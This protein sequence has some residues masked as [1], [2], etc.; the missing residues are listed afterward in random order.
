MFSYQQGFSSAVKFDGG[1]NNWGGVGS[2]GIAWGNNNTVGSTV[3]TRTSYMDGFQHQTKQQQQQASSNSNNVSLYTQ[4]YHEWKA[5]ADSATVTA[6][7]K[8]WATYYADLA[9]R[10]AHFFHENPYSTQPPPMDLPPTPP[11]SKT[12]PAA[13][14]DQ[15]QQ[16]V[17]DN[18]AERSNT[19]TS[20][21]DPRS[22]QV[23]V[24]RCLQQCRTQKEKDEIISSTKTVLQK[25]IREGS[26]HTKDWSREPL[27]IPPSLNTGK[28][29][30]SS[31]LAWS[32]SVPPTMVSKVLQS[33]FPSSSNKASK[34]AQRRSKK[35]EKSLLANKRSYLESSSQVDDS[36]YGPSASSSL[37]LAGSKSAKRSKT[38]KATRD[39]NISS[40]TLDKR[41]K[42]FAASF[43]QILD[44]SVEESVDQGA[45][46]VGTC[47]V[48]EKEYL[49]LTSAP[50]PELVRPQPILEKHFSNL[51]SEYSD[52]KCR[53]DYPWF[54]S[55]LKAIRQDCTVQH[56]KNEFCVQV[57]EFHAKVALENGGK[58]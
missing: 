15:V 41:A 46:V 31:A 6:T 50:K 38:T 4:Y 52:L 21:T 7:E 48:Y 10:A 56:I 24:D 58:C 3:S 19:N 8:E 22:F 53:R 17:D 35:K 39:L 13:A 49:R 18:V 14:A 42:R 43:Q 37:S 11:G 32:S 1:N 55:Q 57:Y 51:K 29:S 44:D 36:Y 27:L 20:S 40:V 23:F 28:G 34:K 33:N 5:M 16:P 9:S 2:S 25:A 54:C 26:L 47:K 30:Q 45:I 12:V